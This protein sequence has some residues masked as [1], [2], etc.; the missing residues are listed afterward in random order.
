MAQDVTPTSAPV[1]DVHE[2][3]LVDVGGYGTRLLAGPPSGPTDWN[4]PRR[5]P[6]LYFHLADGTATLDASVTVSVTSGS[7][8]EHFPH[9]DLSG[10]DRVLAW[11]AIHVRREGCHVTGA[12][13]RESHGCA[14][15]DGVCEAAELA[16]YETADASCIDF[17]GAALNHLFYRASGSAPALPFDVTVRGDQV[18]IT[19]ARASDVVGPILYVHNASGTVTVSTIAAPALGQS[20]TAAPPTA[21]DIA[22]ARQALR[23]SMQQVGLTAD[24]IGAFER[25]W[26]NDLFGRGAA[27]DLSARRATTG[28]EDYLLYTM[29]ASLVDGASRVTITPAPRALRRYLLVRVGV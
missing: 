14:T 18:S 7:V 22:G 24:E 26:D 3:G 12:P 23:A 4:A 21:T 28:P 16:T 6:V 13:A 10:E 11:P 9:G 8:V 19:H 27:R 1:F 5:K 2:W 25:A 17:R 29:P 20:V 15:P